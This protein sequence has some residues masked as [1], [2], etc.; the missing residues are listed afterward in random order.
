MSYLQL[1]MYY[2]KNMFLLT[3]LLSV[4]ISLVQ[5]VNCCVSKQHI[6]SGHVIGDTVE[7]FTNTGRQELITISINYQSGFINCSPVFDLYIYIYFTHYIWLWKNQSCVHNDGGYTYFF[8]K[9]SEEKI[10]VIYKIFNN[11]WIRP[12]TKTLKNA[13]HIPVI[14]CYLAF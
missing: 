5:P 12:P 13:R 10:C 9:C 6:A 2:G 14:H 7:H 8:A 3:L 11:V 4:I 1:L